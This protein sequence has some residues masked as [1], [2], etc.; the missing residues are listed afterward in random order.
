MEVNS[1][2]YSS[3]HIKQNLVVVVRD[4]LYVLMSSFHHEELV[5][6][7]AHLIMIMKEELLRLYHKGKLRPKNL[8]KQVNELSLKLYNK[9]IKK[10][11]KLL[12]SRISFAVCFVNGSDVHIFNLGNNIIYI[13]KKDGKHYF[14][15]DQGLKDVDDS[16]LVKNN[17]AFSL[18]K[19][20]KMIFRHEVYNIN[21]LRSVHLVSKSYYAAYEKWGLYPSRRR[22]FNYNVDLQDVYKK[23]KG[24]INTDISAIRITF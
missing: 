18:L 8:E 5:N 13:Q 2:N 1:L 3:S 16:N 12:K 23:V 17:K 22:L 9:L 15:R 14:L 10:E 6:E 20:P 21:E 19:K 24:N 11:E 7:N 4:H